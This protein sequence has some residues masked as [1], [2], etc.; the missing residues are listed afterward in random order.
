[1]LKYKLININESIFVLHILKLKSFLILL[2]FIKNY[3][4]GTS[5]TDF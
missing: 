1:M 5:K 2:T 3:V 4:Y